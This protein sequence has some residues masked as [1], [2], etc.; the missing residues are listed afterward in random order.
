MPKLNKRKDRSLSN[1]E[2]EVLS[3]IKHGKSNA[4][5]AAILSISERTIKYHISNILMKLDA[6]NRAHAV[7]IAMD[8]NMLPTKPAK[9]NRRK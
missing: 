5:I 9:L 7:A 8:S 1:K 6:E 4:D 3:W 2:I